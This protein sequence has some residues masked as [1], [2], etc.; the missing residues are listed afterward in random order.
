M[1]EKM[2]ERKKWKRINTDEGKKKYRQ[3]NNE[4]RRETDRAREKWIEE[5]CKEIENLNK[6]GRSDLVYA[7][8]K[9]LDKKYKPNR[10][11][12]ITIENKDGILLKDH[13]SIKKRWI[14]YIEELYDKDCKPRNFHVENKNEL[15]EEDEG[16]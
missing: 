15:T 10:N 16:N 5:K 6:L 7:K 3:L 13:D 8:A 9:E 1:I 12:T 11:K 2:E 4:L 14:E